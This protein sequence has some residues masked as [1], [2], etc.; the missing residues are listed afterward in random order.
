MGYSTDLFGQFKLSKP[1]SAPQAERLRQVYDSRHEE[2]DMWQQEKIQ[3][4]IAGN[5][6]VSIEHRELL[7]TPDCAWYRAEESYQGPGKL[8]PSHYCQWI[9]SDDLSYLRWDGG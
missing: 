3:Y 5:C 9:L 2:P 7:N 4:A 1:L 6:D 8:Y